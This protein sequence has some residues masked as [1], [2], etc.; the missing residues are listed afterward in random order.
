[1][2]TTRVIIDKDA[3][4]EIRHEHN[5]AACLSNWS[6]DANDTYMTSECDE[7][8]YD[9]DIASVCTN[10]YADVDL[11][12]NHDVYACNIRATNDAQSKISTKIDDHGYITEE[13]IIH[14]NSAYASSTIAEE[15][16]NHD[17]RGTIMKNLACSWKAE[18][19]AQS[20]QI[21]DQ[22]WD[23]EEITDDTLTMIDKY[24]CEIKAF[25]ASGGF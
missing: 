13:E 1:M 22:V 2:E 16:N 3:A 6:A 5:D 21:Y 23:V 7:L 4:E 20:T 14:E 11:K 17:F 12:N 24:A 19:E 15:L 9:L 10:I 18:N 8:E 25:N